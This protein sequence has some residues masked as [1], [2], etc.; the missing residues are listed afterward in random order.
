MFGE[1]ELNTDDVKKILQLYS[2]LQRLDVI[3]QKIKNNSLEDICDMALQI[4]K[5]E[6]IKKQND[7]LKNCLL[8]TIKKQED[9]RNNICLYHA[10]LNNILRVFEKVIFSNPEEDS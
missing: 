5:N 7:E 9:I 1:N 4:S 2:N 3:N 10:T 8:E 6:D